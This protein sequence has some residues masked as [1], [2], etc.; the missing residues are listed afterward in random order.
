[1]GKTPSSDKRR[2]QDIP[3]T[4]RVPQDRPPEMIEFLSVESRET[5]STVTN[6]K[7]VQWLGKPV[8]MKIPLIRMNEPAITVRRPLAYWIPSAWREVITHLAIHGIQMERITEPREVEVEMYRIQDAKLADQPLSGLAVLLLEPNS[9]DSF[10]QI[11]L[12][13]D[14]PMSL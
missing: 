5:F 9:P 4:W 6:S 12:S 13:H 11:E 3:L 10:F 1:M 2:Q 14:H 7:W 8:T